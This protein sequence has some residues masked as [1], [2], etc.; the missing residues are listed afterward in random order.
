[1]AGEESWFTKFAGERSAKSSYEYRCWKRF[2]NFAVD[3]HRLSIA[4]EHKVSVYCQRRFI[5]VTGEKD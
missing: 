2:L 4:D 5:E 1:M 3:E